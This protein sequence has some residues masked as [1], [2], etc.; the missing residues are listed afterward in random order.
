MKQREDIEVAGIVVPNATDR[1]AS[2]HIPKT[3]VE[4]ALALRYRYP[5]ID[6]LLTMR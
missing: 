4:G 3:V 6:V 5:N 1:S 2:Q